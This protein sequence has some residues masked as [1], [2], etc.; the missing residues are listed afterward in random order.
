[1][2]G[3]EVS[4]VIDKAQA[5]AGYGGTPGAKADKAAITWSRTKLE[6]FGCFTPE[7]MAKLR[8]GGSPAI[9]KGAH[10]GDS[11]ALDHVLPRAIVPELA[12]RFYNL[13][14]LPV[15]V[16]RAKSANITE[17]E[18]ALARRWHREGLLSA[19]GLAAVEAAGR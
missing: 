14:A 16:N 12:A 18:I 6:D 17:R 4:A 15:Q 9:T 5:T 10:A 2:R 19:A 13:E 1:V 3:G 8:R 7:G 11:I